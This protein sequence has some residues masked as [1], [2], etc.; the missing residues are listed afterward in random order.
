MARTNTLNLKKIFETDLDDDTLQLFIDDANALVNE[1]L[2]GKGISEELLTRIERYVAA[3]MASTRD[4]RALD[5]EVGDAK[6]RIEGRVRA[7]DAVG[8]YG[9]FYGQQAIS[10]DPTGELSRVGRRTATL[11][12]A[13]PSA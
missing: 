7:F 12:V 6:T 4:P 11:N 2:A 1:R 5:E 10:L 8:L 3:H 9:T 13:W